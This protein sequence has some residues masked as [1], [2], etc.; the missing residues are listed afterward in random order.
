MNLSLREVRGFIGAI[1][2]YRRF[3][4]VF[5]RLAGPLITLKKKY[6][7]FKWTENCQKTFDSLKEQLTA[8]PLLSYPDLR[9]P[10]IMYT[11]VVLTRLCHERDGP[12]LNKPEEVLVYFL[13]HRFSE[14]Q[15]KWHIIKKKACTIIY[16]VQKLDYYLSGAVFTIKTDHKPLKYLLEAEWTIKKVQQR[17]LKLSRYSCQIFYLT[18]KENTS[19]LEFLGGCTTLSAGAVEYAYCTSAEG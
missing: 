18:G 1:G 14:T 8:I 5:P 12:V 10:M 16:A 15:Q 4:P 17:V 6:A 13:S 11:G 19:Y 9:K 7:R 3:I 2:Y